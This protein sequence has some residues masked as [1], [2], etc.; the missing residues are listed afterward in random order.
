[1]VRSA[2]TVVRRRKAYGLLGS[3]ATTRAM[4]SS[5]SRQLVLDQIAKDPTSKHGPKTIGEG[6]VFEMGVHLTWLALCYLSN[7]FSLMPA[8]SFIWSEMHLHDP[9]GFVIREPA[10]K[11]VQ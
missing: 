8:R 3:G 6:I 4:P 9:D 1:M 5:A 10:A 2:R 11:K 7:I